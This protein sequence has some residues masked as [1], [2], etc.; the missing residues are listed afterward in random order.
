MF[1]FSSLFSYKGLA[2]DWP[3]GGERER[4]AS[5][6]LPIKQVLVGSG[7][8]REAWPSVVGRSLYRGCMAGV[9]MQQPG[10]QDRPAPHPVQTFA[11]RSQLWRESA[12]AA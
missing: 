5:F 1:F 7:L 8:A 11:S 4:R 10:S 3:E 12:V 6:T 9:A 2:P